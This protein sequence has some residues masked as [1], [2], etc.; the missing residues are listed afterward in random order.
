MPGQVA[1]GAYARIAPP[2]ERTYVTAA[3]ELL[4]CQCRATGDL[5]LRFA[6][7]Q[8]PAQPARHYPVTVLSRVPLTADVT[9]LIVAPTTPPR[10]SPGRP[11]SMCAS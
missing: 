10:P 6:H 11:G 7:W 3:D 2:T 4:M 1:G 9:R 5:A 8:A